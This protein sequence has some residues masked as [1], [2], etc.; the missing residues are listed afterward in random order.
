[1]SSS[2][3]HVA[4]D[5]QP[6]GPI[7][8]LAAGLIFPRVGTGPGL[9]RFTG[10]GSS[11]VGEAANLARRMQGYRTPGVSQH[12][13]LRL[14]GWLVERL[15]LEVVVEVHVVR[16]VLLVLDGVARAADLSRKEERVFAEHAAVLIER[17]AG[18]TV[19]NAL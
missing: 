2:S 7:T 9:Y 8:R 6:V 1:M 10:S 4:F 11:Y 16:D 19:L 13:N 12:T 14:R 17:T 18:R 3:L 15:D 5:W